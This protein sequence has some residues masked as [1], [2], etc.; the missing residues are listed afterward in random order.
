[1]EHAP[2]RM[3]MEDKNEERKKIVRKIDKNFKT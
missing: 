2:E 1:L 3:R